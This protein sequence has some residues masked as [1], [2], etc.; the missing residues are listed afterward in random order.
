MQTIIYAVLAGLCWG[1]GE[2]F[3]KSVLH[4]H[5]IGPVTALAI[6][7]TFVLPIL[8]GFYYVMAVRL[9]TE[10]VQWAQALTT[11]RAL[12]MKLFLGS[13][14]IAG[15]GGMIFFY[16][17]LHSGDISRVKPIAFSVAPAIGVLIGWM[18]MDESMSLA[19]ATGIVCVIAGVLLVSWG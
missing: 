18:L 14:I 8:W 15:A 2:S 1:V 6:R 7:S 13:G 5:K 9:K 11:D 12:M 16:L 19:K 10:P 17:A 3:T 4:T